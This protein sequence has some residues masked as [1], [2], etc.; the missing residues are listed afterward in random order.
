MLILC[1]VGYLKVTNV[2]ND[3][4]QHQCIFNSGVERTGMLVVLLPVELLLLL[5]IYLFPF[6]LPLEHGASM[7]LPVS[8]QFLNLGQSVVQVLQCS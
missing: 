7:K 2:Q 8:L 6:W 1:C 5:F 3:H 4:H